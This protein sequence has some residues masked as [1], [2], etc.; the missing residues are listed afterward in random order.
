MSLIAV[1]T[2]HKYASIEIR[3]KLFFSKKALKKALTCLSEQAGINAAIILSTCN[4]VEVY[5]NVSDAD[6]CKGSLKSFLANYK[7]IDLSTLEPHLYTYI[8][9]EAVSHLFTVA[10]GLDSR[11]IGEYQILEQVIFAFDEAKKAGCLDNILRDL[12]DRAL[13]TSEKVRKET[14]IGKGDASI[15]AVAVNL[16][17]DKVDCLEGKKILIIGVGKVSELLIAQLKDQKASMIFVSNR[18]FEKAKE[19]AEG[20]GAFAIKFELLKEKLQEADIIISTTSSPHF[21][22]KKEDL[23]NILRKPLLIV[24]LAVPRD[25]DPRVKDIEGVELYCLDDLNFIIE[26]DSIGKEPEVRKALRIIEEEVDNLCNSTG[27]LE[28]ERAQ[29]L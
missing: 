14:G 16:I 15:G 25:I 12:F 3:E 29:A 18:T 20:A 22:L 8:G 10:A 19:L 1:G 6:W 5:A 11:I 27:F 9:K 26:E 2:N 13:K 24:D 23:L 7:E 4:R 28:L 17:K 21:I